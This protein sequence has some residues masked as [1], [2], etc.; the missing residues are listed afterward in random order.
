MLRQLKLPPNERALIVSPVNRYRLCGPGRVWLR[1][2]QEIAARIDVGP[3]GRPLVYEQVRTAENIPVKIKVQLLTRVDPA[4][5]T[6]ELLPKVPALNGG[7]WDGVTLWQT[8]YVLR[9]LVAQQPWQ[10]LNQEAVQQRL[11]R[12]LKETLADR[13]V[14]VGLRVVNTALVSIELPDELQQAIVA[15]EQ[16]LVQAKLYRQIFGGNLAQ[17][18]PLITQWE[19]LNSIRKNRPNIWLNGPAPGGGGNGKAALSLVPGD[20]PSASRYQMGLPLQ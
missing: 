20:E 3:R 7:G 2:R 15:A 19:L 18:L 17:L 1:L 12:Q 10:R 11:E 6:G 4:L 8:E 16:D 14:W 9:L 13:L 5:L